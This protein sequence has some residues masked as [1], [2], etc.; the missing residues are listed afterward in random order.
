MWLKL[1][2]EETCRVIVATV[3]AASKCREKCKKLE[4]HILVGDPAPLC[5]TTI[6]LFTTTLGRRSS[7]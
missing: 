5:A 3:A 2:L 4:K 7:I 6:R 1:H